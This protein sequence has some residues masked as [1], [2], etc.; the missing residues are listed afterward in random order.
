MIKLYDNDTYV[1]RNLT[2]V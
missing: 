2:C 1:M